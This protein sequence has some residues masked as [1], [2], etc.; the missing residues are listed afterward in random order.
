MEQIENPASFDRLLTPQEVAEWLQVSAKSIYDYCG[1][2]K[3]GLPHIRVG[4]NLRFRR[5]DIEAWLESNV[6]R[7]A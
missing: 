1:R 5:R 6:N 4:G 3:F 7:C 2:S